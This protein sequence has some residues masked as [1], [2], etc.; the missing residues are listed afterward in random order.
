MADVNATGADDAVF[1]GHPRGLAYIVF[2]EAW[3][4]LSFY[5]IRALSELV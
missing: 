3:E 1:F 4:R 5:G 2:T